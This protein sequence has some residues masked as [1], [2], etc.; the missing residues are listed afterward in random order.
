[1]KY[2]VMTALDFPQI[3]KQAKTMPNF[4][5]LAISKTRLVYL[6]IADQYIHAL[7]PLLQLPNVEKP[8]YFAEG[9]EGA[10][11]TVIYPEEKKKIK[12]EA[13]NETHFFAI[14]KLIA[15]EI[16]SKKYYALLIKSPSLLQ[17]RKQY[18]L[19]NLLSFKGYF[20]DFHI[21]IGVEKI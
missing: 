4:G 15:A 17:L 13:L 19:S 3:I 21:T 9:R 14:E 12:N 6:D 5:K 11:I 8:S 16:G 2:P 1:M 18:H 10:H 7:Y 20:I